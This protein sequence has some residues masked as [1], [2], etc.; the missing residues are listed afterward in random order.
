MNVSSE[1]VRRKIQVAEEKQEIKENRGCLE[2]RLLTSTTSRKLSCENRD[3]VFDQSW[4]ET[5]V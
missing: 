2:D 3:L 5:L 1:E 4:E